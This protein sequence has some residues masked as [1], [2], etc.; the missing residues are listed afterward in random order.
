M[1]KFN[2]WW[3]LIPLFTVFYLLSHLL[4]FHVRRQVYAMRVVGDL[5]QMKDAKRRAGLIEGYMWF[6]G[7]K[8]RWIVDK[9]EKNE[10]EDKT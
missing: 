1:K 5:E 8:E 2:S 7:E 3:F 9:E 6:D 10:N 4:I